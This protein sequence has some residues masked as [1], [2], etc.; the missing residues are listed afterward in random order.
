MAKL[1]GMILKLQIKKVEAYRD[2]R[3]PGLDAFKKLLALTE[4]RGT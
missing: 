4:A 2:T 1:L 3:G